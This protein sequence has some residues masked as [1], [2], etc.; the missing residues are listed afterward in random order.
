MMVFLYA[1]LAGLVGAVIMDI[2]DIYA[3]KLGISSGVTVAQIGRWVLFMA[4]G[5]TVHDDIRNTPTQKNEVK[6]GW[7]FHFV[8]GG[9]LVGVCYPLSFMVMQIPLPQHHLLP[10]VLFGLVTSLLPWL[11]L[12]PSFGWGWFGLRAPKG[13]I[14]LVASTIS[15][16]S[17]GI[18]LGLVMNLALN[19]QVI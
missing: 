9:G 13:A 17:Y 11:L 1:F 4:N 8:V 2:S 5:V 16:I 7:I 12:L 15:H 14:P 10:G 19:G 18:G 3:H 6:I